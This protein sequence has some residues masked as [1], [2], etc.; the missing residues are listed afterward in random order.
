MDQKKEENL[1]EKSL[2][3]LGLLL[4]FRRHL[5]SGF[6]LLLMSAVRALL[7]ALWGY[8]RVQ[9]LRRFWVMVLSCSLGG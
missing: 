3:V 2:G 5:G 9:G 6:G 8:Q 7:R 1:S 4:R